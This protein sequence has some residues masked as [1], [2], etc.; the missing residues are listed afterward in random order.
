MNKPAGSIS[1]SVM[2]R[3][4]LHPDILLGAYAEGIFPMADEDGELA[5]FSPDPRAIL[6]L[7][8]F[9][10]A[11][12]LRRRCASQRFSVTVNANFGEVLAR[13]AEREE[14]TW[15]SEEIIQAY[16]R[17]HELGFAHSVETRRAGRLVG[18]LYGV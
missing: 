12:N 14:G 11:D 5:W 9:H 13:C 1:V 8:E 15:V 18:G 2:S 16:T 10:I 6:P 17:L 3:A 4:E 7:D